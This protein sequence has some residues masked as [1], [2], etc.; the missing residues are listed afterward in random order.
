MVMTPNASRFVGEATFEH[1]VPIAVLTDTFLGAQSG[2]ID[3][4]DWAKWCDVLHRTLTANTLGKLACGLADDALST[5]WMALPR[6]T[7]SVLAPAMNT[8]MWAH[9][10]V[11]RNLKWLE[12][13]DRYTVVNPIENAS[14]A[15]TLDW[16]P[17]P[18]LPP[19][20][21]PSSAV[22]E[23][24]SPLSP[25]RTSRYAR[26]LLL[27]EIGLEG[28]NTLKQA[29]VFCVGAGGLGSI[30]LQYLAAAGVGRIAIADPDRVERSNLQRQTLHGEAT[31]GQAKVDS[32]PKRRLLDINPHLELT[33]YP[34][35]IDSENALERLRDW[36]VVV[37]G[38]DNFP[39]AIPDQRC[40]R[41]ARQ[42]A[43]LRLHLPILKAKCRSSTTMAGPPIAIS[44]PPLRPRAASPRVRKP[45]YWVSSLQSLA[46]CKPPSASRFFWALVKHC[47]GD[48]FY[49]TP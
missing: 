47:P 30:V 12:D 49:T 2:G 16:A 34:E 3:H 20:W 14:P 17:W 25:S 33:L 11:E 23:K 45:E 39:H 27:P 38:S 41:V 28:Q 19:F 44:F 9:P 4:V 36:D 10:V 42:A 8:E 40:L 6:G 37:D 46:R 18:N 21:R 35:R 7:Q 5:V 48:S 32:L 26:H 24:F 29:S 22:S 1:S 15:A 43:C 31:L 13:M